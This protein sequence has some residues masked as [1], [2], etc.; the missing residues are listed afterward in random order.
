MNIH[1]VRCFKGLK[2]VNLIG[3]DFL[4]GNAV[5]CQSKNS[6][7]V[8]KLIL[9]TPLKWSLVKT[10]FPTNFY[11]LPWHGVSS[12]THV[13]KNYK[14]ASSLPCAKYVLTRQMFM[15]WVFMADE[16]SRVTVT[17]NML[18]VTN[19]VFSCRL[20]NVH[21]ELYCSFLTYFQLFMDSPS[22]WKKKYMCKDRQE[23]KE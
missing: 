14:H 4:N 7:V 8:E 22:E 20:P 6:L 9:G 19:L 2:W 21:V 5:I 10:A 18:R 12:F 11:C 1:T 13:T 17:L 23:L 3:N 16:F 15:V